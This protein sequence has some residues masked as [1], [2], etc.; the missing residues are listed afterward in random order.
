MNL[1]GLLYI[2]FAV[3]VTMGMQACGGDKKENRKGKTTP[4]AA[5]KLQTVKMVN[6]PEQLSFSGKVEASEHSN[7]STRIMGQIEKYYVEAGQKVSRGQLLLQIKNKDILAKKSQIKANM[8]KAEAGL[9]N[10]QKDYERFKILFSQKSASQKEMDD[11]TTRFN[12]AKADLEAAQQ[13]ESEVNEMLRYAAIRAPY[14]GVV[15]RK[16]MNDGDLAA[17]GMPL[18]AMEKKGSFKVMARIPENEI[19]KIKKNTPV[20]VK[21]NALNL[22]VDGVVAEV[23]P[24]ALYTGNQFEAKIVL[25]PAAAQQGKLFSGMYA[26]VLLN[27]EG[28]PAIMIP[29]K[30]LIKKGQL[31]GVYTVGADNT[32]IL[33][34][35]RTGKTAGGMVEVI[36]GLS[37]GEKFIVS[38]KGKLW[39]GAHVA[40]K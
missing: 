15:T 5:V 8:V 26:K 19:A 7:I 20:K 32:A 14:S 39:N 11:M 28:T 3:A 13:M 23:N 9:K 40:V 30:V 10:A 29:K 4:D 37:S 16:Y 18:I 2:A 36:S 1:K 6:Q 22:L 35:I 21:I 17:P 24:S 27:T 25:R 34:W 33:R 12:V 38:Y 31:T